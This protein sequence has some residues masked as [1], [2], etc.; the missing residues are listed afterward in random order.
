MKHRAFAIII[1]MTTK[2]RRI[3]TF[4]CKLY[5]YIIK[6]KEIQYLR[7]CCIS[8]YLW[9]FPISELKFYKVDSNNVRRLN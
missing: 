7:A 8:L 6:T 4:I 2:I 1:I 3:K 5:M 9:I